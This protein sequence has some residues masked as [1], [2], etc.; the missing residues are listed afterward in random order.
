[1][2]ERA[3]IRTNYLR[4][5]G[6]SIDIEPIT[7]QLIENGDTGDEIDNNDTTIISKPL[8]FSDDVDELID[9]NIIASS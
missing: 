1:M 8:V 4:P 6:I 5:W 7:P 2:I 3:R 9:E